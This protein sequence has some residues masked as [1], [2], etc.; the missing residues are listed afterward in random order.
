MKSAKECEDN[1]DIVLR[2]LC[3]LRGGRFVNCALI[4][5]MANS[6]IATK[7]L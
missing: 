7:K 5:T 6:Q 1:F 2:D 3:V 4:L